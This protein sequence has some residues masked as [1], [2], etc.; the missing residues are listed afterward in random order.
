ML[1]AHAA[2]GVTRTPHIT[3]WNSARRCTCT[4]ELPHVELPGRVIRAMNVRM[5]VH[6]RPP[7]H[8]IALVRRD[9][10]LV[11]ERRGVTREDVTALTQHRHPNDQHPIVRRPVRV[12][13]RRAVLP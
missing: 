4:S 7:E 8:P 12:M 2:A 3:R 5:A 11:I 6:T 13:T 10:V 1:C 9:F